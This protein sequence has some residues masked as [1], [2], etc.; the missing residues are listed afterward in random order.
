MA[1]KQKQEGKMDMEAMMEVYKKYAT[2]GEPHKLLASL[3]GAW[4]TRTTAWM[5]PDKPPMEGNGTCEQKISLRDATFSRSIQA[6]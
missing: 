3:A 1:P 4:A 5:E 6:R 2:P